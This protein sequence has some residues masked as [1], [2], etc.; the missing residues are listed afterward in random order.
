M[1]KADKKTL[2]WNEEVQECYEKKL[3]KIQWDTERTEQQTGVQE[4]LSA[5]KYETGLHLVFSKSPLK[6]FRKTCI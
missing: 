2:R 6:S 4:C 5:G 3:T 1:S